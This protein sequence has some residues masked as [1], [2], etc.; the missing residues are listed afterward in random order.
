MTTGEAGTRQQARGLATAISADAEERVIAVDRFWT[1]LSFGRLALRPPAVT[2]ISGALEPPWPDILVTCGRRG[3][4]AALAMRRANAEPMVCAHIQPPPHPQDFDVVVAL[5]HDR[6]QGPNVLRVDTAMHGIRAEALEAAAGETAAFADLPRPWTGVLLGG[7]TQ[8]RPFRA[9][10]A[11]RLVD[12]L[13]A[14]RGEIGGS[15]VVTPS[16]RTPPEVI[17][18]LASHYA[19]DPT[20]FLWN[21]EGANPYVQILAMADRL[22][23]TSDSVSMI[24]EALATSA[25]VQVFRLPG[26]PRHARFVENLLARGLIQLLDDPPENAART[27]IDATAQAADLVLRRAAEIL[28]V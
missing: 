20:A 11:E 28:S 23:V 6:L 2:P 4:L 18:I 12:Q 22:V 10:D 27:P 7:A 24:S 9:E 21:G 19:E 1:A 14:L 15:L 26:S 17:A 13:A 3:A 8:H 25:P 5:S 16:R